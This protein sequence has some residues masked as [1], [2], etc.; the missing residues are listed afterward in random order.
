MHIRLDS[1]LI[2]ADDCFRHGQ[3]QMLAASSQLALEVADQI[4]AAQ[5]GITREQTRRVSSHDQISARRQ[6]CVRGQR[7][8]DTGD[9]SPST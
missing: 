5:M 6:R 3:R 7:E 1:A 4:R 2:G 9:E 8:V